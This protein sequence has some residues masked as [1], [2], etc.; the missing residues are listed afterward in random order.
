VQ[1]YH[2]RCS[3]CL[4]RSDVRNGGG[5]KVGVDIPGTNYRLLFVLCSFVLCSLFFVPQVLPLLVQEDFGRLS[6][7]SI[8]GNGVELSNE[9][10]ERRREERER[11]DDTEDEPSTTDKKRKAPDTDGDGNVKRAKKNKNNNNNGE[12][13]EDDFASS[14][15]ED[16][17]DE[18]AAAQQ[19]LANDAAKASSNIPS[20][21][22][23]PFN[24]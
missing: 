22:D 12:E 18:A 16:E 4:L 14:G 11:Q 2:R 24:N 13:E 15:D 20:W 9:Q 5:G 1:M 19:R 10:M 3:T 8:F 21:D 23:L 17:E 6:N 7:V